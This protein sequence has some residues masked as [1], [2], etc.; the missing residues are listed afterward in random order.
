MDQKLSRKIHAEKGQSLSRW[1]SVWRRTDTYR[2]GW[3]CRR[4]SWWGW[5][6][7]TYRPPFEWRSLWVWNDQW[8]EREEENSLGGDVRALLHQRAPVVPEAVVESQLILQ[9]LGFIHTRMRVLPLKWSQ[10]KNIFIIYMFWGSKLK[11][12]CKKKHCYRYSQVGCCHVNP[13]IQ[14]KRHQ[15]GEKVLWWRRP[16][17][18][19]NTDT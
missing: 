15:K 18:V 9:F 17:L 3:P 13:N 19:Q 6:T 4:R 1:A 5:R 16:F 10:S 11:W 2:R 12:P 7:T 14:R 8:E